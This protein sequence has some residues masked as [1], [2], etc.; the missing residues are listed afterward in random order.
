ML[1]PGMELSAQERNRMQPEKG[2]KEDPHNKPA[3]LQ[4]QSE[5]AGSLQSREEKAGTDELK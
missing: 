5:R 2:H 3:L 1:H 4:R